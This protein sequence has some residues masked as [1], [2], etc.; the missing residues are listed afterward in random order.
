V[1]AENERLLKKLAEQCDGQLG[2]MA[3]AIEYLEVPRVK[4][5]RPYKTYDGPLTLGD[6]E[7]HKDA[8]SISVERYFKTHKATVPPAS[9]VVLKSD[10]ANGAADGD[11]MEG[12]ESRGDFAAVK[13]A[14]TYKVNDPDAP[15]GKRDVE[16]DSLAK[17]Y[18]YGRTAVHI[19]EA[20]YN[21]T[22]LETTKNF[23]IIGFIQQEKV[24]CDPNNFW[25]EA[26]KIQV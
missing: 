25:L 23:T 9:R 1:K 15:G 26:N 3:E 16:F 19:S 8:M 10:S 12:I 11:E 21:I 22:K 14:R 2:T 4:P 7:Q 6:P 5:T 13:N 17:G 18:E 24:R 20:E